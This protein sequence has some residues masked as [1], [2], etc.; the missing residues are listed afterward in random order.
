MIYFYYICNN[1][2]ASINI[3]KYKYAIRNKSYYFTL[4]TLRT[5]RNKFISD[6]ISVPM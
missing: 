5:L 3:K 1:I 2:Y 4:R 6:H